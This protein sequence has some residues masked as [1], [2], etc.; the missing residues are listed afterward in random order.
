IQAPPK[1]SKPFDAHR[2]ILPMFSEGI[3]AVQEKVVEPADVDVAMQWGCG[4]TKGLL[5]LA[6]DK[7]MDWCLN[8]LDSYQEVYGE[9]FRAAWLARKL[10]R[11]NVHDFAKLENVP[12]AAH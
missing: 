10:V 1:A 2:L 12:V 8:Q 5:K 4:M 11:A 3:Y 6:E 7:G 9:R